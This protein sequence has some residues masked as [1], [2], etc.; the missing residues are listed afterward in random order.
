MSI[1]AHRSNVSP[2][3]VQEELAAQAEST[4][5]LFSAYADDA[6]RHHNIP[7]A[8]ELDVEALIFRTRARFHRLMSSTSR[9]APRGSKQKER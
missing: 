4:A 8:A 9:E 1:R 7:L 3:K 5:G 2:H 6:D